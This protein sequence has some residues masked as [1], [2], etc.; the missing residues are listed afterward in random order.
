MNKKL[1]KNYVVFYFGK[2]F[3]WFFILEKKLCGFFIWNQRITLPNLSEIFLDPVRSFLM[4]FSR[5]SIWWS[6]RKLCWRHK[7]GWCPSNFYSLV[8]FGYLHDNLLSLVIGMVSD[9]QMSLKWDSKASAETLKSAFKISASIPS[10]LADLLFFI[11]FRARTISILDGG[12]VLIRSG[13]FQLSSTSSVGSQG[14]FKTS[15][16]CF[17]HILSCSYEN[18]KMIV[19]KSTHHWHSTKNNFA[20]FIKN[21]LTQIWQRNLFTFFFTQTLLYLNIGNSQCINIVG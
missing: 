8:L 9:V 11:S 3:K 4:L 5:T 14:C 10:I 20:P 16:K 19:H 17:L 2:I 21:K 13:G 18:M 6:C 7:E 1:W 12:S 15:S